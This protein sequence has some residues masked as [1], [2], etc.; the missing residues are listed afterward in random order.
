MPI[1]FEVLNEA[2]VIWQN[3]TSTQGTAFNDVLA[4]DAVPLMYEDTHTLQFSYWLLNGDIRSYER[5]LSLT[6]LGPSMIEAVYTLMVDKPSAY[7]TL[8][9]R[10]QI[11]EGFDSVVGTFSLRPNVQIIE[12]GFL[13][14]T[15]QK[16]HLTFDEHTLTLQEGQ[17]EDEALG[18]TLALPSERRHP[19]TGEFIA[20]FKQGTYQSVAS[21]VIYWEEGADPQEDTPTVLVSPVRHAPITISELHALPLGTYLIQGYVSYLDAQ[22]MLIEDEDTSI[23]VDIIEPLNQNTLH[24][25]YELIVEKTSQGLQLLT[26]EQRHASKEPY[27]PITFTLPED[28]EALLVCEARM[29]NLEPLTIK[30]ITERRAHYTVE[31]MRGFIEFNITLPKDLS[32]TQTLYDALML[33]KP[34]GPLTIT[35][36][37]CQSGSSLVMTDLSEVLLY[38]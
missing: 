27:S 11:N 25:Y 13:I 24:Q 22:Y 10:H 28:Y 9:E 23:R 17:V 33:A 35:Y 38:P 37:L 8:S 21:Y 30:N 14:S 31:V 26:L 4:L 12:Y 19:L 16:E 5:S 6:L 32:N 20:S 15:Q 36:L 3:L 7:I 34:Q 2:H 1:L 18:A 29:V